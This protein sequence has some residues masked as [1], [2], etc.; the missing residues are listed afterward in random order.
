[1]NPTRIG[2]INTIASVTLSVA[3][4]LMS[5]REK[6]TRGTSVESAPTLTTPAKIVSCRSGICRM[7]RSRACI[8]KSTSSNTNAAPPPSGMSGPMES[9][10]AR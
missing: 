3:L 8:T 6:S 5:P 2:T 7:P 4:Q 1:M 9:M 10:I